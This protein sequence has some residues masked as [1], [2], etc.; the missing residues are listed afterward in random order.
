MIF[1]RIVSSNESQIEQIAQLLLIEKMVIDVNI[2]RHIERALV[3]NGQLECSKVFLLTAKTR[4]IL[5]SSI[6]KLV[7]D[8][9]SENLPEIYALPIMEMDWKQADQLRKE[10]KGKP[11][12]AKL[13]DAVHRMRKFK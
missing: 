10:V 11:S 2:K 5:F 9:F 1:L 6:D 4:A 3:V 12:F 7:N 13:R 8:E